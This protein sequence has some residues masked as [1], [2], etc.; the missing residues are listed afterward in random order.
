[1]RSLYYRSFQ[2]AA[3]YLGVSLL[4]AG[5]LAAGQSN[6]PT[7]QRTQPS[8]PQVAS[9]AGGW[10]RVGDTPDQ[11][12][13][14][15]GVDP[16]VAAQS[17]TNSAPP[18]PMD[19]EPA[20]PPGAVQNAEPQ[21]YGQP[22]YNQGPY[23]QA[24]TY[25]ASQAP[26]GQAQPSYPQG[27]SNYPQGPAPYG[28]TAA[29]IPSQLLVPAGTFITVRVNQSLSS[30]RN[31]QGD[32]FSASLIQP[33]VVN[34]VVVAEPGQT[35]AGRVVEA[36]KAGRVE[37][38]SRLRVELTELTLVDG[39]QIPIQTQ[40]IDRKGDTSVGRDVAGVAGTSGMGAAIGAAAGWG[41]GAAIG[42]GAGAA[43][44]VL[45]VLLTRGEPS[46][47][48]PE[49]ALTFRLEAPLAINTDRAPQAFRYVQP[50]EYDRPSFSQAPY[51]SGAP[52]Y[53]A[54]PYVAAYPYYR[55]YPY[56]YPYYSSPFYYGP[57]FSVFFGSPHYYGRPY[58]YARP[59]F[60]GHG[61]HR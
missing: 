30:D 15:T 12:P 22:G 21:P 51:P 41:R 53:V 58:V 34:G 5:T 10:K 3:S 26:Y 31:Q 46:V 13:P 23:A 61:T 49:Q 57:S 2:V 8:N 55:P 28:A 1:M 52:Q 24:P 48:V 14:A 9:S 36:Q 43:V 29:P 38:T 19:Q 25:G 17:G 42:A 27:Q 60:Y 44:G 7:Q 37:G 40:L 6:L 11:A 16:N 45:G 47:I 50:N 20:P 4:A 18:Q 59:G 54:A 39:Q 56:G 35:I 33:L 32:P